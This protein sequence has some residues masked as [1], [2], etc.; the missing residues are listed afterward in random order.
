MIIIE[1][2]EVLLGERVFTFVDCNAIDSA[3]EQEAAHRAVVDQYI[4]AQQDATCI[5]L[6]LPE[7]TSIPNFSF[8]IYENGVRVGIYM[9]ASNTYVSG[10][11]PDLDAG[12]PLVLYGRH[13]PGF[14]D[15]SAEDEQLLSAEVTWYF[16]NNQLLT[17]GGNVIDFQKI[18]WAIFLGRDD[19]NSL[20]DIGISNAIVTD[21]RLEATTVLD[22]NNETL[23]RID[24]ELA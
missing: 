9:M 15:L 5:A 8:C 13:M 7:V 2:F 6:E 24:V 10:A 22:E 20:R 14:S 23:T 16:L 17:V 19:T 4:N 1:Q 21:S 18:S 11:W 12:D 3:T